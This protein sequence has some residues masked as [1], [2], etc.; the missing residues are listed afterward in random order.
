MTVK[1]FFPLLYSQKEFKLFEIPVRI[2]L[3]HF[4]YFISTLKK[5]Q[6]YLVFSCINQAFQTNGMKNMKTNHCFTWYFVCSFFRQKLVLITTNTFC[7]V[8]YQEHLMYNLTLFVWFTT[9]WS[10]EKNSWCH[11]QLCCNSCAS[12]TCI[13]LYTPWIWLWLITFSMWKK[14]QSFQNSFIHCLDMP[15][16]CWYWFTTSNIIY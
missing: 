10:L 6:L 3:S 16:T 14:F 4:Y 2:F 8:I 13:F 9:S 5:F 11:I 7:F 1:V 12:N 15:E